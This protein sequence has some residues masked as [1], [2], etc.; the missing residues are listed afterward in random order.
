MPAAAIHGDPH[1]IGCGESRAGN[2]GQPSGRQRGDMLTRTA[3]RGVTRV[4]CGEVE[5]DVGA[6]GVSA[7]VSLGERLL[8]AGDR[9]VD[10]SWVPQLVEVEESERRRRSLER[11][12]RRPHDPPRGSSATLIASYQTQSQ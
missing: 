2:C 1:T 12:L 11:R 5:L 3:L 4:E 6:V 10:A 9:R 8:E 7:G